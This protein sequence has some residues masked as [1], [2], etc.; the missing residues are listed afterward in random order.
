MVYLL[1]TIAEWLFFVPVIFG[2]TRQPGISIVNL[3]A[4]R[5]GA[6][7][8]QR[9]ASDMASARRTGGEIS[10]GHIIIRALAAPATVGIVLASEIW[11]HPPIFEFLPGVLISVLFALAIL[12]WFLDSHPAAA[13]NAGR[14]L[15]G[16]HSKTI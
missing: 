4:I 3:F 9:I 14:F 8:L 11:L 13:R 6:L 2:G 10:W 5:L 1:E 12:A 7:A 16:R 15:R